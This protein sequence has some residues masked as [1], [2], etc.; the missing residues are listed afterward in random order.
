VR[1][2]I[3]ADLVK[4]IDEKDIIASCYLIFEHEDTSMWIGGKYNIYKVDVKTGEII[5][6]YFNK[7]TSKLYLPF[8]FAKTNPPFIISSLNRGRRYINIFDNYRNLIR[9]TPHHH[10]GM[11]LLHFNPIDSTIIAGGAFFTKYVEWLDKFD[12]NTANPSK[13]SVRMFDKFYDSQTAYTI[14]KYDFNLN[15]IDSCNFIERHGENYQGYNALVFGEI[16]DVDFKNNIY[17]VH[18]SSNYLIRKYSP[19]LHL[20]FEFYGNNENFKPIPEQLNRN[21]AERMRNIPGTFSNVYAI[22]VVDDKIITSFYQ[23]PKNWDPPT[24]PFYYDIFNQVG[25]KLHTGTLPYRIFTRDNNGKL[26]FLIKKEGRWPFGKDHYYLVSF[27]L[28]DLMNDRVDESFVDR[29]IKKY[30]DRR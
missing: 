25:K 28:E 16:F 27:T 15:L 12:E 22:Y 14:A 11:S 30:L 21:L 13:F 1:A 2:Q 29:A 20:L 7:S 23:N 19:D 8:I 24:P 4:V 3:V 5:D 9:S 26:Y 18:K 17:T 10:A 6:R